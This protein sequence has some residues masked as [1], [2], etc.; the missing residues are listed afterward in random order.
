T[1]IPVNFWNIGRSI[2]FRNDET[3]HGRSPRTQFKISNVTLIGN[4]FAA[5]T[6]L[7]TR[8]G[9]RIRTGSFGIL[10]NM[11]VTQFPNDGVRVEDLSTTELGS[12]MILGNTR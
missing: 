1:L 6:D 11:V 4:G 2:E 7:G 5:G 3:N 8:R 12:T 10:Q 9:V